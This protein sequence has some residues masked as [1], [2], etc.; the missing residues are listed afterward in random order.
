MLGHVP[1]YIAHIKTQKQNIDV[2]EV[3][4]PL[5]QFGLVVIRWLMHEDSKKRSVEMHE[6]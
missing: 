4:W 1:I 6:A 2:R 5:S 3:Q